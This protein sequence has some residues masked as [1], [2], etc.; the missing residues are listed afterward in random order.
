ML[1]GTAVRDVREEALVAR[2]EGKQLKVLHLI[3][4]LQ[5]GGIEKWLLTML[6]QVDRSQVSIDFCC[7]GSSVGQLAPVARDKGATVVHCPLTASH[8]G[9]GRKFKRLVRQGC[10]DIVHNHLEAYSGY[11]V[12]LS[13]QLGVPVITSF[14]N[15]RFPAQTG[16]RWPVLRELR[17][18]YSQLSVRYAMDHSDVVTGCS[19]GVLASLVNPDRNG[20][21]HRV[22][23]YGIPAVPIQDESARQ[24]FRSSLGYSARTPLVLH[25]GRFLEQK[26]H[27]GLLEIWKRVLTRTP[28]ARLLLVG[29]GV[30]RPK[31]ETAVQGL[32]LE[33]TVRFL[34]TRA[35]VKDIMGSCDVFLF[36]SLHEG[37][38]VAA[39]EAGGAGLPLVGT[40][41]PGLN[42]IVEHG[43]TG[44][45]HSVKDVEGMASSVSRLLHGKEEVRKLGDAA[46]NRVRDRFSAASS[47]EGL[48]SLYYECLGHS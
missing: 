25:V 9:F 40:N 31:V 19:Q 35:D 21:K 12:W 26:N 42:E 47:A 6:E 8:V 44:L 1:T 29:D 24:R 15:T 46:R 22:L 16:L 23:Y 5:P 32:G 18:L 34:G 13:R 2:R 20:S 33:G 17:G 11:P 10:Y 38:P 30:L 36:P 7:K 28:M 43:R 45:L 14:H 41:V 4:W 48:M 27:L 39:L 37:L 3:T